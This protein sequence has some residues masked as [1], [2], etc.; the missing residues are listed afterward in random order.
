MNHPKQF[1]TGLLLLAFYLAL[2]AQSSSPFS[3]EDIDIPFEKYVLDNG[4]RLIVHEDHK[5][6]YRS[7]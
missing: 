2:P 1:L 6:R 4:L 5:A 7:G 3:A